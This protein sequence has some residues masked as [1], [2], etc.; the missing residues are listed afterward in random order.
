MARFGGRLHPPSLLALVCTASLLLMLATGFAIALLVGRVLT[1][2]SVSSTVGHD[3]GWAK[4]FVRR[5]LS[6]ADLTAPLSDAR[7]RTLEN[8]LAESAATNGFADVTLYAADR[9]LLAA[10]GGPGIPP[11]RLAT[12]AGSSASISLGTA[13]AAQ[14]TES[15][16]LTVDSTVQAVAVI[17]RDARPILAVADTVRQQVV[18]VFTVAALVLTFLLLL[19]FRAAQAKL[20]WQSR[21]LIQTAR[22][23]PV[24][25]LPNHGAVVAALTSALEQARRDGGWLA[26][27]VMDIDNFEL[28]NTT[29]GH[30]AGDFALAEVAR[31]LREEAPPNAII[32]RFGPDE[33]LLGG[34]PTCAHEVR[35]AIGRVRDRLADLKPQLGERDGPPLTLSAG[36]SSYPEHAGAVTE[37]LAAATVTLREAKISGGDSILV[38][39]PVVPERPEDLRNFGV[40]RGLV[41]AIDTKDHFT[42]R[43]A[44]EVAHYA[45][46]LAERLELEPEFRQALRLAGLLHDV[47]KIGVPDGILRKPGP[48][49]G[50]E[51]LLMEQHTLIGDLIVARLPHLELVRAGVRSHH[52]RWDGSGYPDQLRGDGIPRI[53]RLLAVADAYSAMTTSRA[54]RA[55]LPAAE[56]LRRL[57]R[58]SGSQ[59]EPALVD[60]FVE[61]LRTQPERVLRD[62]DPVASRLWAAN[63]AVA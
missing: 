5:E 24:T 26:V 6:A 43:H 45:L 11:P 21:E 36:V 1:D 60:V 51:R 16:P 30:A 15:L 17:R 59:L 47:G 14:L 41:A 18:V 2:A 29:H 48:L 50:P 25:G 9:T 19:I 57:Q 37:L 46:L 3:Q 39:A 20:S 40:L 52:E 8:A 56:A 4:D 44:E 55:G 27:A 49:T 22:R 31:I 12:G 13:P 10:S 53:A 32:G 42:K 54:Y 61:L 33:F 23:D 35:P 34:P 58:A 28:F 63:A 62:G 7:R 38:D